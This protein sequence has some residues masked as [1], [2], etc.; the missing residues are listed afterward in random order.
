[1]RALLVGMCMVVV[2]TT[3]GCGKSGPGGGSPGNDA[4]GPDTGGPNAGEPDAP[5]TPPGDGAT[6]ID[7]DFGH[8][9][10]IDT[11]LRSGNAGVSK[12]LSGH[13]ILWDLGGR[14]ALAS[15]DLPACGPNGPVC[16]PFQLALAGDTLAVLVATGI[17]LHAATTGAL[18]T[19]IP[20]A[21]NAGLARDGSYAWTATT[22]RLQARSLTGAVRVD[23]AGDYSQALVSAEPGTLRIA[24]GPVDSHALQIVQLADG[25]STSV[26]FN[27]TFTS[28]FD[29]G[30]HFLTL[31]G[32]VLSVYDNA[33]ERQSFGLLPTMEQLTG[34]GDFV[35][36]FQPE[37]FDPGLR[38]Y[39][40]TDLSA[41]RQLL[42]IDALSH[43]VAAGPVIGV[44]PN[45]FSNVQLIQLGATIA[46]GPK[47]PVPSS[48][49]SAFAG[50]AAGHWLVGG[51]SGVVFDGDAV[52]GTPAS[53]ASLTLGA[54]WTL[55]GSPHATAVVGTPSRRT[56]VLT[57]GD[58]GTTIRFLDTPAFQA[59]ITSDEST[60]VASDDLGSDIFHDDRSLRVLTLA[61]GTVTHTF[62]HAESDLP[63]TLFQGFS[64]AREAGFI[65][66]DI[67]SFT[68]TPP[69][70]Q[71][72]ITDLAGNPLPIYGPPAPDRQ[73]APPPHLSPD[74]RRAAFIVGDHSAGG[75]PP[76][77]DAATELYLDGNLAGI[78]EGV[79]QTWLDDD[80]VLVA[81]WKSGA[82]TV[83]AGMTAYD[84]SGTVLV[85]APKI[86]EPVA[87][88]GSVQPIDGSLVYLQDQNAVYDLARDAVVW[89][90]NPDGKQGAV[91]GNSIIYLRGRDLY[92]AA[93]RPAP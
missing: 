50:D 34:Q 82:P 49:M 14:R 26:P 7:L 71:Y 62:R 38:I 54:P 73:L 43:L 75:G 69:T 23:L 76:V 81:V 4:G 48:R 63:N 85:A 53:V 58:P 55:A 47:L 79:F 68:T 2:A 10:R 9:A 15:G 41:P 20:A 44:V 24:N 72:A 37:G 5:S 22:T 59:A 3:V 87:F 25:Q 17:E 30:R 29:D 67:E 1:M 57:L 33:G 21:A 80:R 56:A 28:W 89:Q 93:F 64:V 77:L 19:T 36:T 13:W 27:G 84:G 92:R 18:L 42:R 46:L 60:L 90:G 86:P 88:M 16:P 39:A 40:V 6:R 91:V 65:F 51:V 35:W 52:V 83:F 31:T 11:V 78:V 32:S 74:G 66:H 45:G 12:D 61:T 8:T 70:A